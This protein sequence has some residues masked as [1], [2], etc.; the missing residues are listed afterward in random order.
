MGD[1]ASIAAIVLLVLL[2]PWVLVWRGIYRRKRERAEDQEQVRDLVSRTYTPEGAVR[3]LQAQR[4]SPSSPSGEGAA[5]QSSKDVAPVS[6]EPPLSC[7][8]ISFSSNAS[9]NAEPSDLASPSG[10]LVRDPGALEGSS[11]PRPIPERPPIF[12]A[13]D[14]TP[15]LAD[16]FKSSLDIEEMMGTN[17]LNKLGIIILVLGVAFFL[18]YQLKTLGPAGKVMVG[19]ATAAVM[20]GAGVW[21]DRGLSYRVL[22]RA[23]I[24]GGWALSFFTTY[25]MYHVPAAQVLSSQTV[26]LVLM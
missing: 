17:W 20:L 5:P 15:S 9:R 14:S 12:A 19:F 3:A 1:F 21:F 4:Y 26:D 16:R 2:G 11:A 23:G 13:V 25:A 24:G 7:P 22:A 10:Q 18:A 8:A 6:P